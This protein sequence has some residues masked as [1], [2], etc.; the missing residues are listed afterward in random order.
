MRTDMRIMNLTSS[1]FR[2]IDRS[3][4][5][6]SKD[7]HVFVNED[8][9]LGL[10]V[11]CGGCNSTYLHGQLPLLLLKT[12]HLAGI[13]NAETNETEFDGIQKWCR[14]ILV[15]NQMTSL[16]ACKITDI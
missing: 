13:R 12:S 9:D 6:S 14:S 10:I 3:F 7:H 15:F 16:Y 8:W 2:Q 1:G 11:T 5:E 4:F